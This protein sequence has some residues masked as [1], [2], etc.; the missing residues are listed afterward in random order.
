ME[1]VIEEP[2]PEESALEEPISEEP[3][4]GESM[5]TKTKNA[6]AA[7]QVTAGITVG[8][9]ITLSIVNMSSPTG[10]W[11]VVNLFQML[12]LLIL[13]GAFI[14]EALRQ[15]LT[16]MKFALLN[17]NFIP[18]IRIPFIYE[19]HE[20]IKFEQNSEDM[21]D[22][23]ISD[24]STIVNNVSFLT[25]LLVFIFMHIPIVL[26]YNKTRLKTGRCKRVVD[27][28]YMVMTLAVY[29][30]LLQENY[31]NI[32]LSSISEVY[33]FDVSDNRRTVSLSV[34]YLFLISSIVFY[35][36]TVYQFYKTRVRSTRNNYAYSEE[37][38]SGIKV[39]NKAR[40]FTVALITRILLLGAFMIC[41][42]DL[43]FMVRVTIFIV[44]QVLF[45]A[46]IL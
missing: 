11:L 3:A 21:K 7:T 22:V 1:P 25:T 5:S 19:A 42:Q 17:F 15:Y 36:F 40:L 32:V 30:R 43:H 28:A 16:G 34:A 37:L 13:T 9:I 23:G 38:F 2:T 8:I 31:Q 45:L 14:P 4:S 46:M 41:M 18:Y 33:N 39:S 20:W 26:I 10:L 6:Q 24:G 29:I 35:F 12:M 44:I 27:Y